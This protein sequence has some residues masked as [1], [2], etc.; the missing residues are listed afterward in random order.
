MYKISIII[1]CFN[2]AAYV[3]QAINSAISQKY[4]NKEIIV[5][6]DGSDEETKK[7]LCSWID[8]IDR[9]IV[10]EN[11]GTSVAR[12]NGIRAAKGDFILVLDSDDYFEADFCR[13]AMDIF[14]AYSDCKIVTCYSRWFSNDKSFN[15]Y[16][17]SGGDLKKVLRHN[18]AMG[19]SIYR[20]RD[21]SR[22]GGYDEK[23][24]LGFEDWEFYIRLLEK[25]GKVYVIPEVLFHYR[26]KVSSRNKSANENKFKILEYIYLKHSEL[27]KKDFNTFIPYLLGVQRKIE[28]ERDILKEKIDFR[29]GKILLAPFRLFRTIKN[30]RTEKKI[31]YDKKSDK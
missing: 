12:N 24:L 29:L 26:N 15:L 13:R 7:V 30:N 20:R 8:K 23:M 17:P 18:I 6:D 1:P 10:Q 9:L 16:K 11:N 19:S 4:S 21:W 28:N 2:E 3:G 25:G 22:A 5:V 31:R 14:T 27:Y